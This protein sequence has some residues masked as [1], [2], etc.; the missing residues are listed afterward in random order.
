M[1]CCPGRADSDSQKPIFAPI[2]QNIIDT[3][4]CLGILSQKGQ[5]AISIIFHKL[6]EI[7]PEDSHFRAHLARYLC[8]IEKAYKPAIDLL[9]EAIEIDA[10]SSSAQD[11]LLL[12][13][14]A[15]VYSAY[16]TQKVIP[17]IKKQ[18]QF[19]PHGS[20]IEDEDFNELK[21]NLKTAQELFDNVRKMDSGIAGHISDIKLCLS[22]IDLGKALD[23]TDTATFL[24]EHRN[25]WYLDLVDHANNLFEDCKELKD[26]LDDEDKERIED[27]DRQL[28]TI[29]EGIPATIAMYTQ[30]LNESPDYR[31]PYIRRYLAR[32]YAEQTLQS[33]SQDDWK[34][35]AELMTDN[36]R[37]DPSNSCNIRVWF[38]AILHI[39][40]ANPEEML[41]QAIIR[42]NEWVTISDNVEAHFYRYVLTFI[43][44]IEGITDAES[45]LP[46]YLLKLKALSNNMLN[47]T[48]FHYWLGKSG[49]GIE[50]LIPDKKFPR[51]DVAKAKNMLEYLRGRISPKYKN[52]THAYITAYKTDI[53]F[54]PDATDQKLNVNNVNAPVTFGIG[55]SF[56]GPRAYN[57]SVELN[58]GDESVEKVKLDPLGYGVHVKC[59]V[60]K[61]NQVN[62]ITVR[63]LG[64]NVE[65]GIE[66]KCL[67]EPFSDLKRP[68]I[69]QVLDAMILN[70]KRVISRGGT[71][72]PVWALTLK[73][74][75]Q[76]DETKEST[77]KQQLRKYSETHFQ[78]K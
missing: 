53:F 4:T 57:S 31:R 44:A 3:N 49:S 35:I 19:E 2:I 63:I 8:Y 66:T 46:G 39:K 26:E 71:Y 25:D 14:K 43:Q 47:R 59:E 42:L 32:A 33:N 22:I 68:G 70:E 40:S 18:H 36:M 52:E 72:R 74:E 11:P 20:D 6:V 48:S 10:D 67:T 75:T 34:Y 23:G 54:S 12:H 56:D 30:Y 17:E 73:S 50:R 24:E 13:M 15:M 76:S 77:F 69:G 7:Y 16:I 65:G 9:N 37:E 61:N 5:N 55:F 45:R 41:R 58:L 64:Y 62:Y 1:N 27:I 60:L 21:A 29:R 38:N 78:D 51:N 28:K